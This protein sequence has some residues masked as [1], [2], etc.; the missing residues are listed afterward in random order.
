MDTVIICETCGNEN[1]HTAGDGGMGYCDDCDAPCSTIE[2]NVIE[3]D[4]DNA[5][6]GDYVRCCRCG[7]IVH[8]DD[9]TL[10][11]VGDGWYCDMCE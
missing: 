6:V 11:I 10:G 5:D 3:G 2:V 4:A 1:V 7:I 8:I 9:D